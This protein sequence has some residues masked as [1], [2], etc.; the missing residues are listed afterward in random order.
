ML[1]VFRILFGK[2]VKI[3]NDLA[4]KGSSLSFFMLYKYSYRSFAYLPI[5]YKVMT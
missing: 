3:G 5:N 2:N 1:T 4:D